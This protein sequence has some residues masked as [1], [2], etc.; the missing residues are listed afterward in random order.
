MKLLLFLWNCIWKFIKVSLTI[1]IEVWS[2]LWCQRDK[3]QTETTKREGEV[4]VFIGAVCVR[5]FACWAFVALESSMSNLYNPLCKMPLRGISP[6][7]RSFTQQND[8]WNSKHTYLLCANY[9]ARQM[10]C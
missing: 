8:E 1:L 2:S 10:F 4:M 5:S 6:I 9:D 7:I 3:E